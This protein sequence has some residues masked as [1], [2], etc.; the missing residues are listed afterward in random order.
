MG[1]GVQ[2][3]CKAR[4]VASACP[5]HVGYV[6]KCELKKGHVDPY[7]VA[8][9]LHSPVTGAKMKWLGDDGQE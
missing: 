5:C 1:F 4:S 7:H 8:N 3:Q 9:G 2:P 6:Y